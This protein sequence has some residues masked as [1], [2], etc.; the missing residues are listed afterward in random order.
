MK[1]YS[2]KMNGTVWDYTD[3]GQYV[4]IM[5]SGGGKEVRAP[6]YQKMKIEINQELRRQ[7]ES[8]RSYLK[9]R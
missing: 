4:A 2:L 8:K 5:R 3:E 6:T 1:K 9:K 7:R